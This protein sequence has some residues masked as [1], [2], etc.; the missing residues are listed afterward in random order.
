M[1]GEVTSFQPADVGI[2]NAKGEGGIKPYEKDMTEKELF[3]VFGQNK[4]HFA[5]VLKKDPLKELPDP[6][7]RGQL[8]SL[9]RFIDFTHPEA[10]ARNNGEIREHHLVWRLE[11]PVGAELMKLSA[12]LASSEKTLAESGNETVRGWSQ[13]RTDAAKYLGSCFL[14]KCDAEGVTDDNYVDIVKRFELAAKFDLNGNLK[15][16][17]AIPRSPNTGG[18]ISGETEAILG[19]LRLARQ[20]PDIKQ[21]LM[22]EFG[23]TSGMKYLLG[24]EMPPM[25]MANTEANQYLLKYLAEQETQS[26]GKISPEDIMGR[27]IFKVASTG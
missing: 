23:N 4:E 20:N 19:L 13:A 24:E 11:G 17:E 22:Q 1:E 9:T 21:K 12:A 8:F 27:H 10:L 25:I 18:R 3:E 16:A 5:E 6:A 26:V 14:S 2:K 15:L 7:I